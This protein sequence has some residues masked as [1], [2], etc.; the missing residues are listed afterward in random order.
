MGEPSQNPYRLFYALYN[1]RTIIRF[2]RNSLI[3]I[4]LVL[5]VLGLAFMQFTFAVIVVI[6]MLAGFWRRAYSAYSRLAGLQTGDA[7]FQ[8]LPAPGWFLVMLGVQTAIMAGLFLFSGVWLL[9]ERGFLGQHLFFIFF[10]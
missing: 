6:I 4:L 1:P 9:V 10:G 8:P 3:I 2:F 7:A 5:V